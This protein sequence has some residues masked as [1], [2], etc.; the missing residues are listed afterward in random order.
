[1]P[2]RVGGLPVRIPP[3]V[4]TGPLSPLTSTW[5]LLIE[6]QVTPFQLQTPDGE[7]IYAWHIMPLP[8]YLQHEAAVSTQKLGLCNNFTQ[9]ESFRLL[10]SDPEARLIISCKYIPN[11]PNESIELELI[12]ILQFM[13]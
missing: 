1:M 12:V 13:G 5:R 4:I 9:T 10:A 8:L 6:N 11:S 2:Q 7:T 3:C